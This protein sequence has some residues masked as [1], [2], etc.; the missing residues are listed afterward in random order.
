M[1]VNVDVDMDMVMM[2]SRFP[3]NNRN[4]VFPVFIYRHEG[5]DIDRIS[6]TEQNL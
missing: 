1:N 5:K 6:I 4:S 2:F 3:N